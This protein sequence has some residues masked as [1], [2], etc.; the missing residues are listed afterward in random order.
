M[1]RGWA[2]EPGPE[3]AAMLELAR[4]VAPV[5]AEDTSWL[6]HWVPVRAYT[7]ARHCGMPATLVVE[8]RQSR[9]K[10]PPSSTTSPPYAKR[11]PS[12]EQRV[13]VDARARLV[14]GVIAASVAARGEGRANLPAFLVLADH[15]T[16]NE[17]ATGVAGVAFE[18]TWRAATVDGQ[19]VGRVL[20]TRATEARLRPDPIVR[21]VASE[22][23]TRER[24]HAAVEIR[25][26][27]ERISGGLLARA[28]DL[29]RAGG[30][31]I[32]GISGHIATLPG[33]APHTATRQQ[34]KAKSDFA[35]IDALPPPHGRAVQGAR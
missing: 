27:Y 22:R 17:D 8:L 14:H 10:T 1:E 19:E 34:V 18:R 16:G 11:T 30:M 4:R 32:G 2:L 23:L 26:I 24:G 12:A 15:L 33:R 3:S 9:E 25:H 29:N 21:L 13:A 5:E 31:G 35:V 7:A 6:G 20:P 28:T